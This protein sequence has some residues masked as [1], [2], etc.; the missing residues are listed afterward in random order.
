[1]L[2]NSIILGYFVLINLVAFVFVW[3]DKAKAKAKERKPE[4][5]RVR[6]KTLFALGLFGGIWGLMAGMRK[7]HHKTR[8]LTFLFATF[9]I[10]LFNVAA[11]Y[12]VWFYLWQW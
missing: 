6:E 3:L 8:K 2:I 7:F 12:V 9:A 1:M 10:F 5:Q 4:I 11:Y